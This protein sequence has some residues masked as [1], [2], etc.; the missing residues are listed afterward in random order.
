VAA[1]VTGG[2]GL[3]GSASVG[4]TRPG[5]FEPV[6]GSAPDIAGK[7]IANPA[8]MLRSAALMLAHGLDQ[9]EEAERLEAAVDAALESTPPPDLGGGATT[10]EVV[11]AVL[12]ALR[13]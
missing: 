2:L 9:S 11:E 4:D 5:I 3:A 13:S 10:S 12:G 8:A 1:G 6:H 7:G